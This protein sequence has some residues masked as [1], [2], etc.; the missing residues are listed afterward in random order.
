MPDEAVPMRR[1][2]QMLNRVARPVAGVVPWW[3]LLE[4]TGRRTGLPRRTPLAAGRFDGS[5]LC[6]LAAYGTTSL[7]VKNIA[8]DPI[9]RVKRRGQG[10][11]WAS[12]RGSC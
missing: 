9:V 10:G 7:F 8:I 5:S 11:D 12:T 4:T 3:V 1:F 2:W 6:V